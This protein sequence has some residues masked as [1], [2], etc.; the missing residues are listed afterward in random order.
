MALSDVQARD[1]VLGRI[2][3][4]VH[5]RIPFAT[6]STKY[7]KTADV[8]SGLV[9]GLEA[10]KDG[11]LATA[12]TGNLYS[13]NVL[14]RSFLEHMLKVMAVFLEGVKGGNE[15]FAEQFIRVRL[16]EAKEYL[17]AYDA[18]GLDMAERPPTGLEPFF[19]EGQKLSNKEAEDIGKPFKYK[20]LIKTITDHIGVAK[21]NILSKIIPNYSELSG[22]VHGGPSVFCIIDLIPDEETKA[23]YI[24]QRADLV[25]S[26]CYSA[27]RYLLATAAEVCGEF[28]PDLTAL[29]EAMR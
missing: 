24:E 27:K 14:F 23:A 6:R 12:E 26:M 4:G 29:E 11:M 18:A 15:G 8:L 28:I 7:A 5:N 1:A 25:V 10:L 19:E 20:A 21:P 13:T 22:F 3:P 16:V 17:K 9:Y 2:A